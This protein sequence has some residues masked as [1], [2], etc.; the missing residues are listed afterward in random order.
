MA[1]TLQRLSLPRRPSLPPFVKLPKGGCHECRVMR[2]LPSHPHVVSGVCRGGRLELERGLCDLHDHVRR[3]PGCTLPPTEA[4][5]VTLQVAKGLDHLHSLGY[6]HNDV[7]LENVLLVEEAGG[8]GGGSWPTSS[9]ATPSGDPPHLRQRVPGTWAYASPEKE[10]YR[11]GGGP[12]HCPRA[13]DMWGPRGPPPH[14]RQGVFPNGTLSPAPS[15]R[16]TSPRQVVATSSSSAVCSAPAASA[17]ARRGRSTTSA[18]DMATIAESAVNTFHPLLCPRR[19][20]RPDPQWRRLPSDH[21][22]FGH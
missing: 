18:R 16:A 6:C 2:A 11:L 3:R 20:C 7:K 17:G 12:P 21:S 10:D 15:S 13:S 1:T 8:R 9:C 4:L 22:T 14:L 5:E 19:G